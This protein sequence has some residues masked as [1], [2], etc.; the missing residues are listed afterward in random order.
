MT[1]DSNLMIG[2][3]NAVAP[4]V[5]TIIREYR[6]A[7]NGALPTDAEVLQQFNAHID[8]YIAEGAAFTRTHPDPDA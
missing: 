1:I 7:H 6:A 8:A 5:L 4:T 3:F 2:L